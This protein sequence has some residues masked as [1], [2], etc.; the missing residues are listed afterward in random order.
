MIL[1]HNP[2]EKISERLES[3][4]NFI[5]EEKK[6]CVWAEAGIVPYKFCN[7]HFDC[8]NCSF[9]FVMRGGNKL[10]SE[11]VHSEGGKLCTHRFYH[12]CHFW[13]QVE[14]NALVRIGID[15]FGQNILGP[16]EKISLP[17]RNEKI[18]KKSILIKARGSI[19]P[20]TPFVDGYVEE[21]NDDLI[22]DPQLANKSP[23]EKGWLVLLRPIRLV[24]DLRKLFYGAAAIKWFDVERFRL[25]ALIISELNNRMGDKSGMTLHNGRL[26]DFDM[27]NELPSS[28]TK[29]VLEQCFLYCHTND[30]FKDQPNP[31]K[32]VFKIPG[33]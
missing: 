18:D 15:D 10:T 28:I 32:N 13:A 16:I 19:I 31:R 23:Y 9:N 1:E 6:D 33:C 24:Q 21:V 4:R 12:H 11:R 27:L 7:S 30:K 25:A 5:P 3:S 14:E 29:K 17:L 20:L 22:C 8:S 2:F 26:P